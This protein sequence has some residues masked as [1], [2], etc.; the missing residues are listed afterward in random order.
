MVNLNKKVVFM[1]VLSCKYSLTFRLLLRNLSFVLISKQS[2][3]Q[4]MKINSS[5]PPIFALLLISSFARYRSLRS[6][7]R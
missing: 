5:R 7:V 6:A 2:F 1:S 3:T 4:G